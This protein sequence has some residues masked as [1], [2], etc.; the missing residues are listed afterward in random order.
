[1]GHTISL[2]RPGRQAREACCLHRHDGRART[3]AEV[4]EPHTNP[5]FILTCT[6]YR[7]LTLVRESALKQDCSNFLSAYDTTPI[8]DLAIILVSN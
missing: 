5:L 6:T 4:G 8:I 7:Y 3:E 2:R 1:M